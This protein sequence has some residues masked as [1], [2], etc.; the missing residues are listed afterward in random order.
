M[1]HLGARAFEEI[2]GEVVQTTSF[3]VRNCN[4]NDYKSV[5]R[6]L[7]DS[8]SQ[9][10]KESLF[11]SKSN[12][13]V[14]AQEQFCDIPGMPIAYWVSKQ[15]SNAF[16]YGTKF[17]GETKKGVLTGNNNRF[18]RLWY[19]IDINKT[20]FSIRDHDDM[21]HSG[22][23]W[24]PVTSGGIRRK[25]YGNFDTVVN[26][27]HDGY[28]IKTYVEN[29]RLR[30][31]QYYFLEAIT[32]TEVSTGMFTCRYVPRG[33]LFGNGGPVCF[34]FSDSLK[35]NLGLLNSK[36]VM[37]IMSYIAP[38]INFGPEQISKIPVFHDH[39]EEIEKLVQ[40]NVTNAKQEWDSFEISWDYKEHPFI[41]SARDVKMELGLLLNG[42]LKNGNLLQK[43]GFTKLKRMRKN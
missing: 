17:A 37:S 43:D 32:W 7:V 35:Y 36:V 30:D 21:V 20:S 10:G 34:F 29:Y 26:L 25:W 42:R 9:K 2:G 22:L 38:T 27:E 16:V 23:K 1:A 8:S 13:F 14:V 18:L 3:V 4:I 24:F 6:R 39:E 31:P 5:Y 40:E 28:E 19:E 41:T 11:L 12:V 15:M 33:I